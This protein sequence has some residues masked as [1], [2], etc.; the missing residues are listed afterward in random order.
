[1]PLTAS[2]LHRI[3]VHEALAVLGD[4]YNR[5]PDAATAD[6][7]A[8]SLPFSAEV[9]TAATRSWV[10]TEAR[11]PTVAAFRDLCRVE[12]RQRAQAAR[13]SGTHGPGPDPQGQARCRVGFRIARQALADRATEAEVL[14]RLEDAGVLTGAGEDEPTFACPA[15]LDAGWMIREDGSAAPCG[16]CDPE[17]RARWADH[18]R[19]GS[20][21]RCE[22][23]WAAR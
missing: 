15:C 20:G 16:Q 22:G 14:E 1:M 8:S 6:L 12:A 18:W 7:W 2:E 19:L 10:A 13:R 21:H 5:T 11:H 4:A 9:V 23:C 3:A 17:A